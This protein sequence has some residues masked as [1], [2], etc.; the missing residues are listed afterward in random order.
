MCVFQQDTA[1]ATGRPVANRSP[2]ATLSVVGSICWM[3]IRRTLIRQMLNMKK[4][5]SVVAIKTVTSRPVLIFWV[6]VS[7]TVATLCCWS[8]PQP[9]WTIRT[10]SGTSHMQNR[11]NRAISQ[12]VIDAD[13]HNSTSTTRPSRSSIPLVHIG[14][15]GL[16]IYTGQE[17]PG[18]TVTCVTHAQ[19]D[20]EWL[21]RAWQVNSFNFNYLLSVLFISLTNTFNST[22]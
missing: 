19:L 4:K 5:A 11:V 2:P 6:F 13:D 20:Y 7:V 14:L 9:A 15:F 18:D 16:C 17:R 12:S 21:P 3:P 1:W 10:S 8:Y 22:G